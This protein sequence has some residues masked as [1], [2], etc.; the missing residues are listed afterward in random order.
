MIFKTTFL[1]AFFFC[2]F[3]TFGQQKIS[4]RVIAEDL[5]IGMG[6]RIFDKDTTEIGKTDFNGYFKIEFLF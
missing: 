6:I 4:G 5:E 3:T 2:L 1:I